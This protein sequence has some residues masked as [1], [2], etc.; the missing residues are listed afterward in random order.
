MEAE[1]PGA[2]APASAAAPAAATPPPVAAA[3]ATA[4]PA[5]RNFAEAPAT[6]LDGTA[7]TRAEDMWDEL[8]TADGA[9]AAAAGGDG[10][11]DGSGAP[12]ADG[13]A[14]ATTP[15]DAAGAGSL[16]TVMDPAGFMPFYMI[17]CYENPDARPGEGI[18]YGWAKPRKREVLLHCS[19]QR[20]LAFCCLARTLRM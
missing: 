4:A 13:A 2:V 19:A 11:A 17:D 6:P 20:I 16:P 10:D 8:Y 1:G 14:A 9:A 12:Q 15:G 18:Q 7:V 5:S 3:A